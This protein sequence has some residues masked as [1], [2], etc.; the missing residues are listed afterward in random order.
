[1]MRRYIFLT[2]EGMTAAPGGSD[3]ENYQ[4]LGFAHG[5]DLLPAKLAL[6]EENPWILENG[7][8]EHEIWGL[9]LAGVDSI[10]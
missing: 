5:K 4:V 1:M 7:F 8:S 6:L 10:V 9:E 3:V 2:A